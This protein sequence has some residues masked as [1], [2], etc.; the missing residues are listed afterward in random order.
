[1]P[2]VTWEAV[3]RILA[4]RYSFSWLKGGVLSILQISSLYY[5]CL[6]LQDP[7][8]QCSN[9]LYLQAQQR[10]C[11]EPGEGKI[12]TKNWES[13]F[14]LSHPRSLLQDS[15]MNVT[16]YLPGEEPK[17]DQRNNFSWVT[18]GPWA[19]CWGLLM[20]TEISLQL[21]NLDMISLILTWILWF[22][23]KESENLWPN[24]PLLGDGAADTIS[25]LSTKLPLKL[26]K[27]ECIANCPNLARVIY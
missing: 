15:I 17:R 26:E 7:G 24:K 3:I 9:F 27:S 2:H 13:M 10:A 23:R 22:S 14:L 5:R 4:L 12:K 18:C 19:V 11:K 25:N 1:M 6:C 20:H 8:I 16:R 21:K